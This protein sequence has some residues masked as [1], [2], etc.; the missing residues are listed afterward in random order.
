MQG[1]IIRFRQSVI[2]FV[3]LVTSLV[4]MTTHAKHGKA[5]Q[6]LTSGLFELTATIETWI[7]SLASGTI[8]I[9][10]GYI[11]L[12]DAKRDQ[13]KLRGK[14]GVFENKLSRLNEVEAE[15]RRLMKL[16]SFQESVPF[17][18]I[19]A[20]VVGKDFN[21]WSRTIV[22]N[23]GSRSGIASGMAV[24][25]PEGVVGRIFSVSPNYALVQLTIDSNSAIP[26]V[27]QRTRAQGIVEGKITDLCQV[28]YLDRL[29]DVKTGD[30]LITSGLGGVYPKGLIIGTVSSINKQPYGLFQDAAISPAVDFSRLEEVLVVKNSQSEEYDLQL[31][32]MQ[33]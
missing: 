33:E 2:L 4:L 15:N 8:G 18:M 10:T 1:F 7:S 9:Y 20:R 16:L 30:L 24:V 32:R 29:A 31:E 11:E 23:E 17:I 3:L 12:V 13:Q 6:S 14:I 25:R 26:G 22:I 28:K 27:F 21:S 5:F 19:P